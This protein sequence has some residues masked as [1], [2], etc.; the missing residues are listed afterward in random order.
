MADAISFRML[1]L[2]NGVCY[3]Q[4]VVSTFGS[5]D[6]H[7]SSMQR[8]IKEFLKYYV[9]RPSEHSAPPPDIDCAYTHFQAA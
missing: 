4:H 7:M 1:R 6:M 2:V 9:L 5:V 8:E 3:R